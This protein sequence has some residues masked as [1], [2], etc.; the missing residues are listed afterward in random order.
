MAK[1][2]REEQPE[3]VMAFNL[4]EIPI[5]LKR[6]LKAYCAARHP[7]TMR[8]VIIGFMQDNLETIPDV[9]RKRRDSRPRAALTMNNIPIDTVSRFHKACA[10]KGV[11]MQEAL[12]HFLRKL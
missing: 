7:L 10:L 8:E 2:K 1:R 4:R 12:I 3:R 9:I 5:S 6:K 11:Y